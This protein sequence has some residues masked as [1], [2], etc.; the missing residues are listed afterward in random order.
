MDCGHFRTLYSDFADGQLDEL[1]EIACHRHLA[2][3]EPC[4]RHH[5]AYRAG[6]AVLR[7][8]PRLTPSA[9]FGA[10]LGARLSGTEPPVEAAQGARSWVAIA[11]GVMVVVV[12][13]AAGWT[14]ADTWPSPPIGVALPTPDGHRMNPFVV[15]FAGDTSLDYPG[16]FP[17]IPVSRGSRS[18]G[19][20]AQ[21]EVTVDWMEP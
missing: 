6:C 1:A 10:R 9:D 2:E 20:P 16:P 8:Q 17:I 5:A 21:F 13:A 3:C 14:L 19:T 4:R 11:G 12:I 7:R 18:A 15:R